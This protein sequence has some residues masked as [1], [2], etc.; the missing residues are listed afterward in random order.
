MKKKHV[1]NYVVS[2]VFKTPDGSY[3]A[4]HYRVRSCD[5]SSRLVNLEKMYKLSFVEHYM[6]EPIIDLYENDKI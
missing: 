1:L 5:L 2:V 6:V 4:R 3:K